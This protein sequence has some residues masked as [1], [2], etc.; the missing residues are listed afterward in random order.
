M[1]ALIVSEEELERRLLKRGETSGRSDDV[2]HQ[3]IRSRIV[4]Y[5]KYTTAVAEY[6]NQFGK[7]VMVEGEGSIDDI[8]NR[9]CTEIELKKDKDSSKIM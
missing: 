1:L 9:L 5:H 7:V 2:N 3:I 8:F 4:E 6:Y